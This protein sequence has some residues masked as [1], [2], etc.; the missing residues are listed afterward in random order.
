MLN[1]DL[2]L[3]HRNCIVRS[4][5][6]PSMCSKNHYTHAKSHST[7]HRAYGGREL[8]YNTQNLVTNILKKRN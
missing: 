4:A 1:L 3:L 6:M 5:V 2:F 8:G 7:N